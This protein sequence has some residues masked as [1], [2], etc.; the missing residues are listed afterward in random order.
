M[1]GKK[2]STSVRKS[3]IQLDIVTWRIE[4][5]FSRKIP[6]WLFQTKSKHWFYLHCSII[7]PFYYLKWSLTLYESV[8]SN[9][10][11]RTSTYV[12]ETW[13]EDRGQV[14]MFKS[15]I[16]ET[17]TLMTQGQGRSQPHSP[18]WARVPLSSFFPQILINLSYFSSNFTHFLPHF[19]S[20]G[21]RLAHP[22]R[23]WLRHCPR[24]SRC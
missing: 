11:R 24:S 5:I 17:T 16:F 14:P 10:L 6:K 3:A 8:S 23:P 4:C 22:G 15:N 12:A 13:H 19:G 7:Y 20:P 21:G 9:A 1:I 18:G 2:R